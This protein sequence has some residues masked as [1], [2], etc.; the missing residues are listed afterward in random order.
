MCAKLQLSGQRGV[1]YLLLCVTR[2]LILAPFSLV[3]KSLHR[4]SLGEVGV[5]DHPEIEI[6]GVGTQIGRGASDDQR[7]LCETM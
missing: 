6:S 4:S 7:D 5:R 1:N 3:L 2:G